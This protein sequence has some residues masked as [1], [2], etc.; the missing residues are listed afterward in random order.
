MTITLLVDLDDTLLSNDMGVFIPAYLRA[1]GK[2]M[3]EYAEPETLIAQ[4]LASTQQML[5]NDRLDRTLKGT[6]DASF[7]PKLGLDYEGVQRPLEAFYA[8]IYPN[9][10]SLTQPR[11]QAVEMIE[12][13]MKLGYQ[14]AIATNPLFPH[15]ATTQRLAWAGL[16]PEKYAF[17]AISTY[18]NFHFAKPNPAYYAEVLAQMGWP[19]KPAVMIGNDPQADIEGA[20]RLGLATFWVVDGKGGASH[21]SNPRSATGNLDEVLPWLEATSPESLEPDFNNPVALKAILKATPAALSTWVRELPPAAWTKRPDAKEWSLTEVLCHLRDS[22]LEINLPRLQVILRQENPIVEG[23]NSDTWA[24]ERDYFHQDGAEALSDFAQTRIKLLALLE[25]L[26]E[27]D[28]DRPARHTI[29]GPTTIQ[30][31]VKFTA[32]HDQLHIRQIKNIL[33]HKAIYD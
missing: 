17:T 22:D 12:R 7:Y 5:Q 9:L 19:E 33:D 32:R 14:V 20:G 3:A 29:F 1:L 11:P 30:E 27:E 25:G 2:H 13:A 26:G 23:V 24:E 21:P 31:L 4:L 28:W 8:D 10:K 6:F 18:E 16:P 15:T